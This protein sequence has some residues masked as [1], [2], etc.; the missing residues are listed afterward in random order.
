MQEYEWLKTV[1]ARAALRTSSYGAPVHEASAEMGISNDKEMENENTIKQA[2]NL[3][4]NCC[5][6][7]MI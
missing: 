6:H 4:D 7:S 1:A 2:N 5:V 3:E